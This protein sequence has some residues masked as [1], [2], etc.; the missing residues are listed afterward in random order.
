MPSYVKLLVG[1]QAIFTG[2][3]GTILNCAHHLTLRFASLNDSK[4]KKDEFCTAFTGQTTGG[5]STNLY[6]GYEIDIPLLR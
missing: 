2:V 4:L 6:E 3:I 5:I 1:F